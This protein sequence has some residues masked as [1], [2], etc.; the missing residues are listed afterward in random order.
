M[1]TLRLA[2]A[3]G[4]LVAPVAASTPHQRKQEAKAAAAKRATEQRKQHRES[5]KAQKETTKAIK[6]ASKG[7]KR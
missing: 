4:L 6:Q 7:K 2:L 1:K 5:V 3:L